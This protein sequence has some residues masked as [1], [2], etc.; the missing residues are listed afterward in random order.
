MECENE[1]MEEKINIDREI[2]AIHAIVRFIEPRAQRSSSEFIVRQH[3]HV[4]ATANVNLT[5]ANSIPQIFEPH[6]LTSFWALRRLAMTGGPNE[7]LGTKCPSIM[8][9]WSQSAPIS[10]I[11]V[12]SRS[13]LAR[14]QER[15]D[16]ATMAGAVCV[17]VR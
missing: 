17:M 11:W 12:A 5:P 1:A 9:M 15:R 8:S 16:G 3:R 13:M 6:E 14:S 2:R 7:R 10:S 4:S